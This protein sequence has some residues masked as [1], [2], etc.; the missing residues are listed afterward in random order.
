MVSSP[1]RIAAWRDFHRR[2]HRLIFSASY[3]SLAD[4]RHLPPGSLK[5]SRVLA[6]MRLEEEAV[7]AVR[8]AGAEVRSLDA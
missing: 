3:G 4:L 2:R 8:G 1:T 5:P 6:S 7:A